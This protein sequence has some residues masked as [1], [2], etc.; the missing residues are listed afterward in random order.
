MLKHILFEPSLAL[1]QVHLLLI[2]ISGR[3]CFM[4]IMFMLFYYL[5]LYVDQR[6]TLCSQRLH[7][8]VFENTSW[9]HLTYG[10]VVCGLDLP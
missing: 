9:A 10:Q 4:Q 3:L 6:S 2:C 5:N 7:G 8:A 1:V